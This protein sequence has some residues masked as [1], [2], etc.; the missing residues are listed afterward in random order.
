MVERTS[1]EQ[2]KLQRETKHIQPETKQL[3]KR[4]SRATN[5]RK[6][7]GVRIWK[8]ELSSYVFLHCGFLLPN[9]S[10]DVKR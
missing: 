5:V 1:V 10:P 8:C 9:L 7:L 2:T 6:V 3:Q 4:M